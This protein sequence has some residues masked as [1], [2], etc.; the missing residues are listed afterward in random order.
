MSV[1]FLSPFGLHLSIYSVCPI[2]IGSEGYIDTTQHEPDAQFV[3]AL[4][5]LEVRFL[6]LPFGPLIKM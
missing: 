3:T 6:S 4:R 1:Y 5:V 2:I